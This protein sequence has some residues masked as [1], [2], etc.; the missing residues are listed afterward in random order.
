VA[1]GV[2]SVATPLGAYS[3]SPAAGRRGQLAGFTSDFFFDAQFG[4]T[5]LDLKGEFFFFAG[6]G[7]VVLLSF[8]N[9]RGRFNFFTF[10]YV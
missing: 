2:A 7:R 1:R 9:Q 4:R 5:A 10:F 3:K 6:F 8:T